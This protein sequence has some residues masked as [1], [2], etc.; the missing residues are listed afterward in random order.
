MTAVVPPSTASL[1]TQDKIAQ[2]IRRS[3][4]LLPAEARQQV[5]A[6]LT[7]ESLAIVAGTL[8]VWPDRTSSGSARS[9]MSL[10]CW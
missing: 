7:P 1:R 5:Q 3:L 6:M 10:C 2:A 8:I 4:P 9:S